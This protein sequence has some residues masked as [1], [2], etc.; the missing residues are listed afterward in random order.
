MIL[1][2][3]ILA[4]FALVGLVVFIVFMALRQVAY[5]GG[6]NALSATFPAAYIPAGEV[7]AR[8]RLMVGAIR[9]RNV[10]LT[11]VSH[12]G[13][14]VDVRFGARP[15]LIPWSQFQSA[16][17]VTV[18]WHRMV[19]L[20][21]GLPEIATVAVETQLYALMRPYLPSQAVLPE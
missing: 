4:A 8:Q 1:T 21:V 3:I 13:F 19:R 9:F 2:L 12:E 11:V 18:C 5:A 17:S 20:S 16:S 7:R 15:V 10:V 14:F 6:L